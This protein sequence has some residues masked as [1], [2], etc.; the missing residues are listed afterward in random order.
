MNRRLR[1]GMV[2]GGDGA[3]IGAV[4]RMVAR[5]D[6]K[7]SLV[8]GC[9][10]ADPETGLASGRNL[11]LDESRIYPTYEIMAKQ[12]ATREDGIDV[13]AVVT[14]NHL[15]FAPALAFLEAGIHVICDK[16]L[17][18]D[19]AKAQRLADKVEQTGL[20]FGLT[21]N[22]TGYP[23][24]RQARHMV[25]NKALG[26]IRVIQV[27]YAQDWLATKREDSGDKQA[28]WRTNPSKSGPAGAVGDIGTHAFQLVAYITQLPV[29]EIAAE[30]TTFVPGRRLDDNAHILLRFQNG[31]RGSLW[32]SQVAT[33]C[34]NNL[35]IRIYGEKGG[36]EW[37]Q[38]H[39]NQLRFTALGHPPQLYTRNGPNL[40][41][42]SLRA[43][44]IPPGHPEGYL[45]AFAQLYLDFAEQIS[46]HIEARPPD[47]LSLF[48]PTIH[49][50]VDGVRFIT[51]AV[52][53]A[54]AGGRWLNFA[55]SEKQKP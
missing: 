10:S 33:G 21:H 13:V 49:D 55:S 40:C 31:A 22:Y 12:E 20:F 16:P 44:R 11:G 24:I 45:E 52:E 27:E 1:L 35:N 25:E 51:R 18:T 36:I 4:H 17:T 7:Y 8:A 43:A 48:T 47:P 46:A 41:A 9:L 38:E 53:S 42:A 30:L 14:P 2:G 34:E 15:H 19:L 32:C 29:A 39:P 37:H 23:L 5:L 50:G 6:D 54:N 3:F 28:S 26:E